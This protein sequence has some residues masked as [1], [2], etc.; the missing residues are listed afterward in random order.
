MTK[1]NVRKKR[2]PSKHD[3]RNLQAY[4]SDTTILDKKLTLHRDICI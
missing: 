1:L 3:T 4:H 2:G